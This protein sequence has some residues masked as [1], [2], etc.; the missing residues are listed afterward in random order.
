MIASEHTFDAVTLRLKLVTGAN[1]DSHL[2]EKLGLSGSAYANL[3]KRGSI[4]FEKAIALAMSLK[5]NIHW[6]FT[7]EEWCWHSQIAPSSLTHDPC[8]ERIIAQLPELTPRQLHQTELM[9]EDYQ[10]LNRLTKE[11]AALQQQVGRTTIG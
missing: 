10:S 11:V 8:N 5:V 4:P 6:L 9:L 3:K 1:S 2:A 7:G